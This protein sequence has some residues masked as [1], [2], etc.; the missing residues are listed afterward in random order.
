M[1]RI[2]VNIADHVGNTPMIRLTRLVPDGV[3]VELYGKLE[4]FNPA[5][6]SRTA[7]AWRCSTPPSA[8]THRAGPHDDRRGDLRQHRHR[9]GVL[10]RGQGL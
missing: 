8:R 9:A 3:D 4:A 6:R 10:L 1:P 2:P 5:A 7:S